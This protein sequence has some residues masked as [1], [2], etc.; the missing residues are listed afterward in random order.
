MLD[1]TNLL[2]QNLFFNFRNIL[3]LENLGINVELTLKTYNEKC[4]REQ[5]INNA[6]L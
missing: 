5:C 1:R 6:P 2:S 4:I 3:S